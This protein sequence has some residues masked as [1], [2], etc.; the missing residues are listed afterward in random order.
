MTRE[1]LLA[2]ARDLEQIPAELSIE[3]S[4]KQD[5]LIDLM[6]TKM[7][8]RPD[9]DS[10]VGA[11]NQQMMKDNHANH[12]RFMASV[13]L[14][15]NPE[16]LTDTVIWVFRAYRSRHFSSTYWS[17]QLNTWLEIYKEELS[18]AC[19]QA[20]LPYYSWMQVNIP[21]FNQLAIESIDAP[22]SA[23]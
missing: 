1:F 16:V 22:L 10:L 13:F 18:D 21:I 15:Y 9:V 23:H 6:N 5:L 3:F 12:A 20:V 2:S 17:A 14:T 4:S 19:Y 7:L 11:N 8:S